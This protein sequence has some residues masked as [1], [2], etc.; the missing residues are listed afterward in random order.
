MRKTVSPPVCFERFRRAART[1]PAA[2]FALA[3]SPLALGQTEEPYLPERPFDYAGISLPAH[4]RSSNFPDGQQDRGSAVDQDNTP[5]DNRITNAGATLGRVLFYDRK[6][7]ANG[8]VACASCH[9]QEHGFSDPARLSEGFAGGRTRRHSMGLTNARFYETGRFFWDERASTLEQQVLM[10]FQD[11]IEMGLTLERLESLVQSQDYYRPL[12]Q[13]AFGSSE[14]TS[15]RIARALAQFVRS[16]VSV[17][18]K[19]DRGRSQVSNPRTA[20]PNFTDQENE[21]KRLFMTNGGVRRT[22]CTVC[23]QSEAFVTPGRPRDRN[24]FTGASNNGLDLRSNDDLGVAET[25]NNGRDT[26]KFKSPSLRNVAV[27][28]PYMHDGR[29]ATLEAVIDHYSDRIQAHSNLAGALRQ[30]G[31]RPEQYRFT[32]EEKAALL[33]FLHTLTDATLLSHEMFADPFVHPSAPT[34]LAVRDMA[35]AKA[36]V[37]DHTWIAIV[38]RNLSQTTGVWTDAPSGENA[39]PVELHGTS[40]KIDGQSARLY[41]VSPDRILA[42]TPSDTATGD[43]DMQVVTDRGSSNRTTVPRH[44]LAPRLFLFDPSGSVSDLDWQ[45]GFL[46]AFAS[47]SAGTRYVAAL[48]RD[49]TPAV[50]NGTFGTLATRAVRP[51]DTITLFATGLGEAAAGIPAGEA[52]APL[53]P[54]ARPVTVRFGMVEIG[55]SFAELAAPGVYRFDVTVPAVPNGDVPVTAEVG[56]VQTQ[57]EAFVFIQS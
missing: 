54:L 56:G 29:F 47:A 4:Y 32:E 46:G 7:S 19:Y 52:G 48:H 9:L 28:A 18:T 8:T 49:G 27:R 26:G 37:A 55:I 21:G 22:P 53:V 38:G 25:T 39:L 5:P 30:R 35:G 43:M 51:G 17:D 41:S 34:I 16:L 14:I 36:A 13:A 45:G 24:E 2:I 42:L 44:A 11:E 20:F 1:V 31:G 12:F 57:S 15:G 40:V 6:L 50:R 23:H 33:A 3:C 10:P